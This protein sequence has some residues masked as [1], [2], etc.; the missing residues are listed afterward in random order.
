MNTTDL[1]TLNKKFYE[2]IIEYCEKVN[3]TLI[4]DERTLIVQQ[5]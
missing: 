4:I 5:Q 3:I 1:E 2:Y